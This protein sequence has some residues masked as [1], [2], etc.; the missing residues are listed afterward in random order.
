M[1]KPDVTRSEGLF[2]VLINLE[3]LAKT[4]ETLERNYFTLTKIIKRD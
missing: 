4:L 3:F 1:I 2:W